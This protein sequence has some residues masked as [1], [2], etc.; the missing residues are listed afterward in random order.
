MGAAPSPPAQ[1]AAVDTSIE[2]QQLNNFLG[3]VE[4]ALGGL[5]VAERNS[6]YYIRFKGTAGTNPELINCTS[7]GIEAL[8]DPNGD[9][10]TP[11]EGNVAFLNLLQ[12]FEI[13]KNAIVIPDIAS[14]ENQGLGGVHSIKGIGSINPILYNQTG[15]SVSA[16]VNSILFQDGVDVETLD[17]TIYDFRGTMNKS[18]STNL[19]TTYADI[20][21]YS[22]INQEPDTEVANYD[23]NGT[24]TIN[25]SN[26]G[27]IQ[28]ITFNITYGLTNPNPTKEIRTFVTLLKG[29]TSVATKIVDLN[30]GQTIS[31][32]SFGYTETDLTG[33]PVYKIQ[34]K[35]GESTTQEVTVNYINFNISSQNPS[36]FTTSTPVSQL[37]FWQ[38]G[39]DSSNLWVT[40]SGYLSSNY[41][42]TPREVQKSL[43][44]GF[45]PIASPFIILPGDKIRFGYNPDNEY[46]IYEVIEPDA[47]SD[48]LLKFKL[49]TYVPTSVYLDN[50]VIFRI[51]ENNPESIIL[52]VPNINIQNRFEFEGVIR[53]EYISNRV[54]GIVNQ[55]RT[56]LADESRR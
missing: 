5:P 10:F 23:V 55:G 6:E 18:T 20:T 56:I 50:F 41:G 9:E 17:E 11:A 14:T 31:L 48:G 54:E 32:L 45:S 26:I 30:P 36:P 28:S 27:D 42:N 24:Y 7:F 13:G 8:I 12:N 22:T 51:N 1:Q 40:G 39:G 2:Q 35:K 4:G 52:N 34:A 16:S 38:R 19:S 29:S 53:P 46:V 3:P 47:A 37:P 43:D 25:S 21:S 33:D 15:S 44:F 49:N